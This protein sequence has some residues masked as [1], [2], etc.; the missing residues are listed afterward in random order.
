MKRIR[1][2]AFL[3]AAAA[4]SLFA[5]KVQGFATPGRYVRQ[6]QP[7]SMDIASTQ[8]AMLMAPKPTPSDNH[9]NAEESITKSSMNPTPVLVSMFQ[10]IFNSADS[11]MTGAQLSAAAMAFALA[12][13]PI[14]DA[15]A[16]MSGGRMGGSFSAPRQSISRPARSSSF[17]S[18]YTPGYSSGYSSRPGVV[19]SPGI[20]YG[21][22]PFMSPFS[23]LSPF[24]RVYGGPGVIAMT[25]GP[26]FFDLIFFGGF[27]FV[28]AQIFLGVS[29][30]ESSSST[31]D[32]SSSPS[33]ALG[34]G[35][36]VVQLSIAVDVP[37]RDDP[38]SI[39]AVLNRL[40]Q[41]AQTDSRVGIQ[42]LS[43]QVA[44]ELL[45]RRSSIVSAST[46]TVHFGDRTK[47]LREFQSRSVKER[48]KF[49]N[50]VISK[51]GGVDYS[52]SRSGAENG[53]PSKA[54]MA[55]VTLVLAIDGDSTKL[56]RINNALDVEEALRKIASDSKIDDCLQ[57]AEILWTP[58]DRSETL[59]LRDVVADYPELRSI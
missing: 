23:P 58:E 25:R 53:I 32:W 31:L 17:G 18:G 20:G 27:M 24:P 43:S 35:T 37:D 42:N 7:L 10:S 49:E 19:I 44:L 47:A 57:S 5:S 28:A 38:N 54:T 33:T 22:S 6:Q 41:T 52:G 34:M 39:L 15:D 13:M 16:A 14:S 11:K 29:R 21:Y 59:S 50:E 45:R 8:L 26:S 55:V 30:S 2:A 3:S 9:S 36:S 1:N 51:Y 56:P 4:I 40:S 12:F 48:S 46:S